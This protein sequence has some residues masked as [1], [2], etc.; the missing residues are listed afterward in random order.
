MTT[1][2]ESESDPFTVPVASPMKQMD[3]IRKRHGQ[4]RHM[5]LPW[6][7]D[8]PAEPS[9]VDKSIPLRTWYRSLKNG[10]L[11]CESS[12][13]DDVL[14]SNGDALEVLRYYAV[15]SGWQAWNPDEVRRDEVG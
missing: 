4:G 13:P 14:R 2:N 9:H 15:T 6:P 12:D 10:K 11:W 8:L 7:R 1:G 3:A 5:R